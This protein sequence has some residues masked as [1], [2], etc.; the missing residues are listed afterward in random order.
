MKKNTF[1]IG[2]FVFAIVSSTG[3][4]AIDDFKLDAYSWSLGASF[5]GDP[6]ANFYLNPAAASRNKVKAVSYTYSNLPILDYSSQL[7]TISYGSF[8][9]GFVQDLILNLADSNFNDRIA[10]FSYGRPL[11]KSVSLGMNLKLQDS[12]CG[13][14]ENNMPLNLKKQVLIRC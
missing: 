7:L 3:L 9:F 10:V 1:L 13:D 8:G 4:C 2:L 5:A 14:F 12:D 6:N 11:G